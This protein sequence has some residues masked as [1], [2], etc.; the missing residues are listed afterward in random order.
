MNPQ[1]IAELVHFVN[2]KICELNKEQTI[3]WE[4]LPEY[5][6]DGLILAIK[7]DQSPRD[8]HETWM[9][10]RLE[11]GWKLGPEK[12]IEKRISPCLVPYDELP[13]QQRIKDSVR[14]GITEF[15]KSRC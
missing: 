10:N 13:Y 12:D 5:M 15:F 6:K 2:N 9:K 1:I 11:N 8:G 3:S 14:K 4:D 7:L